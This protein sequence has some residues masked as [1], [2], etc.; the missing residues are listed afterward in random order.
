MNSL[1]IYIGIPIIIGL[2][3]GFSKGLIKE[4]IGLVILIGGI[5]LAKIFDSS[6]AIWL[7]TKMDVNEKTAKVLAFLGIFVLVAVVLSVL[8]KIIEKVFETIA[9]GG[10]NKLI[11]GLFGGIKYA[12]IVSLL[13][14]GILFFEIFGSLINKEDKEGSLFY[15]PVIQ[16]APA[17]WNKIIPDKDKDTETGEETTAQVFNQ[18]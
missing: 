7:V 4:I 8:G 1:D 2:V 18:V 15:N 13:L 6:L 9:L 17:I 14:N 10:L 11:G 16:L 12:L 5:W 3:I